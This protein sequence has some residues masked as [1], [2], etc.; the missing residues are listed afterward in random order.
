[1]KRRMFKP[2][3]LALGALSLVVVSCKKDEVKPTDD[4]DHHHNDSELITTLELKFTGKGKLGSDT[5]FVVSFND[6]D[7]DGGNTAT[8]FDTINLLKNSSYNVEV[9]LLDK[10]KTPADTISNEV[11]EEA[12]EHLFFYS[13]NPI[14]LVNVAITDKD[15]NGKNLG[16]KSTWTTTNT[17][18]GKVKV[19]L[20]HQP[21]TKDGTSATGD[22]DVEVDFQ[23]NVN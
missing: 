9:T 23:V 13:S 22:T 4:H 1:M 12:N 5:T 15:G 20:M 19:K 8:Q 2:F 7:G 16:L 3:M 11:L 21:G 6:P 10:S 14:G 17:G 18:S